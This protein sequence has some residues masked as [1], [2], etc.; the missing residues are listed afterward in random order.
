MN[1]SRRNFLKSTALATGGLFLAGSAPS[2]VF[3][4]K[5]VFDFKISLAQYSLHRTLFGGELDNLDFPAKAKNDFDIDAVEYVNQFFP[6]KAEDKGYLSELKKR[7]DDLGVTNVLIMIDREGQLSTTDRTE[8]IQAVENHHKWVDAAKFLGCHAIRV[9]LLGADEANDWVDASVDGLG[10]LTEYGAQNEICIIVENHGSF[11]SNAELLGRV[12]EQSNT[13][14]AGTLPDFGNF[15]I[16]RGENAEGEMIC[17]EE[18]DRYK[19]TKE[20]MPYAKG[21]SAKTYTFDEEGNEADMDFPRL[22][23]IVKES[24][25]SG[26][27]GIEYEGDQLP[28]DEGI[29]ATKNL[30]ERLKRESE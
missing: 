18:Y 21:V 3:P 26:Y 6:D 12:M 13:E 29:I 16:E 19:G 17:L 15:C 25:F 27:I 7:T 30:L 5:R 24:G 23:N 8:R 11:S 9:N 4:K 20:M 28:E 10:R 14:W 22:F 2:A 1:Q